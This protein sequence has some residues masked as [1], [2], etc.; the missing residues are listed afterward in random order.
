MRC[1]IAALAIAVAVWRLSAF[2]ALHFY[3]R[4]VLLVP[5][6]AT[7]AAVYVFAG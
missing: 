7:L 2:C 4:V 1:R 3:R 6:F 5:H